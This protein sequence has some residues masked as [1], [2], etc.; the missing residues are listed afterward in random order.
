[1]K[2]L[3][4]ALVIVFLSLAKGFLTSGFGDIVEA[5]DYAVIATA[6]GV[7]ILK[8]H[9]WD[10][11]VVINKTLVF[12]GLAVFI[13]A[14]YV[15]VVVGLGAL[16]GL[17]GQPNLGL[18]IV[19]TAVVAIA[20]APV[21]QRVQR[22]A[23]RLVYGKRA[24]PYEALSGLAERMS[25]AYAGDEALAEMARLAGQA[26][27]ATG[28]TVWLRVGGSM[29]PRGSW[30]D[31]RVVQANGVGDGAPATVVQ[32]TVVPVTQGGETLGSIAL[33]RPEG[34]PLKPEESRLLGSLAAQAG[35]ALRNVGL[36][37]DLRASRL[38]L[39][40]AQDDERRRLERNIHDGAQQRLVALAVRFNMAQRLLPPDD[41][42]D[43]AA[44]E[45]L[46]DQTKAALDDL[47][48]L[49]RGI[50]PPLL[51][52]RGLVDALEAQA[53]RS[54]IPA[55][56]FAVGIG[57]Y[58]QATESAAY[59][60]CLEAMQNVSK[61]AHASRVLIRLQGSDGQ[62]AFEVQDDGVGF[63]PATTPR[64]SGLTNIADRLAALGGELEVR[65]APGQGVTV[66]GRLPVADRA[67][68]AAA[69]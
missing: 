40:E 31:G 51:A 65:S 21:R 27:G 48:N 66:A 67:F 4:F 68:E 9:L 26:T 22:W 13:T 44:V 54:P 41:D 57:R 55:E 45:D 52:D 58:A 19:A 12:G 28:A 60:C 36:I 61:Y 1:M 23:N 16:V 62:I 20:F 10:I 34:Q 39:I 17:G 7:A 53:A 24:T 18:S 3:T 25:K 30:P 50:Y 33:D 32:A 64:G 38:R 11:D 46:A 2:W 59:F 69:K 5:I 63:D 42:A 49:A 29:V 56:V 37:D 8:Y 35:L 47:R 15:A 14:V 6:V 43:R